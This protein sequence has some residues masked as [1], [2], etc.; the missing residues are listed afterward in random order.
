M[1]SKRRIAKDLCLIMNKLILE[2]NIKTY[3]EPFVGGANVIDNI[4]CDN[5]IGGDSNE[6]LI[7]LWKSLQNG[8][9]PIKFISREDY[10][11]I[12]FNKD[13]YPKEVVALCG[14]MASY[15]GN[16]FRAYGG[17]SATKTGFD[18]NFYDEGVRGLM[19][20]VPNIL[21]IE[22]ILGD[23]KQFSDKK[24]CLIY[25]DKP[26]STGD[27]FLYKE[28]QFNHDEFWDW[29]REM[30]KNNVVIVSEFNAPNDFKCIYE[31]Q[32]QKTHANQK[33][34]SIEKLFIHNKT[35]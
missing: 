15:N 28:K 25:C 29:V 30:S 17:Y 18:R 27:K 4:K 12:K 6:Y 3:I 26:Y 11:D 13:T 1:G 33:T 24:D 9:I 22:F 14:I 2:N 31:K 10:Y 32:L 16:W 19:K 8:Y 23:Y 34:K 5:K 20:Q 7:T 35:M 21:D